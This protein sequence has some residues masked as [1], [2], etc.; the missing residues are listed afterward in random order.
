MFRVFEENTAQRLFQLFIFY[1]RVNGTAKEQKQKYLQPMINCCLGLL[2]LTNAINDVSVT[3]NQDVIH[4]DKIFIKQKQ[5]KNTEASKKI[6]PA[7]IE[8]KNK[9]VRL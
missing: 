7:L 3:N 1:I 9:E 6:I 8:Y 5:R 4:I 2:T